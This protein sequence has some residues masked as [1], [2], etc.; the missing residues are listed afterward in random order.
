MIPFEL[1]FDLLL[2]MQVIN[3]LKVLKVFY[4]LSV[5]ELI[6]EVIGVRVSCVEAPVLSRDMKRVFA[7]EIL[8]EKFN[9][10]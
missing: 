1:H 9:N 6:H 3:H 8:C 4:V 2:A 5:H 10:L 7:A